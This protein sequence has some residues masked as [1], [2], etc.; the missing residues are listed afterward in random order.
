[1]TLAEICRPIRE[2]LDNFEIVYREK[3]NTDIDLLDQVI[4]YLLDYRGKQL[5]PSLVFFSAALYGEVTRNT[6][7]A[8]VIVEL[9]HTATLL[10]DDV[11]DNADLRRG[12][13]TVRDKWNNSIAVLSG[14]Y[15]FARIFELLIELDNLSLLKIVSDASNAIIAGELEQARFQRRM[16]I[17]ESDYI[18]IVRQKTGALMAAACELGALTA[19]DQI[20]RAA[21]QNM[22]RFGEKIGIAFQIQDDVL[23]YTGESART[24]KTGGND[25]AEGKMTL[26]LIYALNQADEAERREIEILLTEEISLSQL[27]VVRDFVIHQGGI[28]YARR[29]ADRWIQDAHHHL[30]DFPTEP[31]KT[32][33]LEFTNY[34]IQRGR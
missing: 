18:R 14:D 6:M 32:H 28:D 27:A 31:L 26:P 4:A 34:L 2:H 9:L 12:V 24:G 29:Q 30:R 19:G 7:L 25:V 23:D 15:G 17:R 11:I 8:A 21:G 33:F 13:P 10:H 1:M 20:S 22:A 16:D 3:M 5:R